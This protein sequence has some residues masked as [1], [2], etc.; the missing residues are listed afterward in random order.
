MKAQLDKAEENAWKRL[1]MIKESWK[2]AQALLKKKERKKAI[3]AILK[4]VKSEFQRYPQI[5]EAL[6]ELDRLAE[7]D[8]QKARETAQVKPADGEKAYESIMRTYSGTLP[9]SR[10]LLELADLLY[11]EG[12]IRKA[13]DYLNRAIKTDQVTEQAV[14]L[15]QLFLRKGREKILKILEAG[16]DGE[17]EKVRDELLAVKKGYS[18]TEISKLADRV[19]KVVEK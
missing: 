17:Y 6:E 5:E 18:G 13:F 8:L 12:D 19:L 14:E 1:K 11:L 4:L 3:S 7:E 9:A 2:K 10:A 16:L 15:R